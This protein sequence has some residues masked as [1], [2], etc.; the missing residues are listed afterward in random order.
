MQTLALNGVDVSGGVHLQ[1]DEFGQ[2]RVAGNH[3]Q[4]HAIEGLLASHPE[5]EDAFRAVATRSAALRQLDQNQHPELLDASPVRVDL[6]VDA[7]RT[8]VTFV[9]AAA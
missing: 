2:V 6:F 8:E 9:P 1:L 7:D 5:L 4:K 3:P